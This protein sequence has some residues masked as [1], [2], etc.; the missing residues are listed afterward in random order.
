VKRALL[1]ALVVACGDNHR[2]T[3]SDGSIGVDAAIDAPLD[4]PDDAMP[5]TFTS[6]VI[7]LVQ[8]KTSNTTNAVPFATFMGLPDPDLNNP[9]AYNVL[10]P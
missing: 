9:N 10:F 7:D 3:P 5:T 1:V 2:V 4:A 8:N 6:F